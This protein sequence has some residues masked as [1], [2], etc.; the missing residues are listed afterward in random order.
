M[1]TLGMWIRNIIICIYQKK[2]SIHIQKDWTETT[3]LMTQMPMLH[4]QACLTLC[5]PK[6]C[7]ACQATQS[8]GLHRQEYWSGLPFPSPGDL[9]NPGKEPV[10]PEAPAFAGWLFTTEPPGNPN[11]YPSC[12]KFS[13]NSPFTHCS[14]PLHLPTSSGSFNPGKCLYQCSITLQIPYFLI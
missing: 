2:G 6:N 9:P 5:D 13:G 11:R 7:V 3:L 1:T 8:M 10:S 4:S 12:Y 14:F